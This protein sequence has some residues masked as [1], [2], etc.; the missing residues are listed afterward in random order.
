MAA[1]SRRHQGRKVYFTISSDC[2]VMLLNEDLLKSPIMCGGTRNTL[3]ISER[4]NWRTS[5]YCASSF[6]MVIGA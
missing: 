3:Q 1:S 4:W 5:R 2:W 6:D